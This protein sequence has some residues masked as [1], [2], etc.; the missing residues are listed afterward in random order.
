VC[1]EA[2]RHSLAHLVESNVTRPSFQSIFGLCLRS[3]GSPTIMGELPMVMQCNFIVSWWLFIFNFTTASWVTGPLATSHP[4]TAST[5][6]GTIFSFKG[7]PFHS[8][9]SLSIK[10]SIA[11][12][13]TITVV[14]CSRLSPPR[15]ATLRMIFSSL[16]YGP[17]LEIM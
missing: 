9:Y 6:R 16:S 11:P 7:I 10:F 2:S 5:L 8:A 17:T 14:M 4:S 15:I 1:G 13:S 3:H 12:Q